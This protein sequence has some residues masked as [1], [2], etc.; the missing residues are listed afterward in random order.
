MAKDAHH[1]LLLVTDMLP[2]NRLV[3]DNNK[4]GEL[5]RCVF[6]LTLPTALPFASDA[7]L[8]AASGR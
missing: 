6:P 5:K 4:T 1:P 7:S 3:H 8:E 2:K